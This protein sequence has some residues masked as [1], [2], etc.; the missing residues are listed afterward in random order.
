MAKQRYIDTHFWDDSF[1][2]SLRPY[3]RY[4]FMY[5]LTNPHTNICGIYELSLKKIAAESALTED[6]VKEIMKQFEDARKIFYIDGWVYIKNFIRHQSKNPNVTKG[7]ENK[8]AEIPKEIL[9]KIAYL[10]AMDSDPL[11]TEQPKPELEPKPRLKPEPKYTPSGDKVR[12]ATPIQE[13]VNHLFTLKGWANKDKDFYAKN[14]VVYA[15]YLRPAKDLLFLCEDDIEE[16]KRCLDKMHEW[17]TSRD[18]DWSIETVFKKWPELD[19]LKAKEKKPHWDGCRVFQRANG[20]RWWI[21]RGGEI[22]ELGRDLKPSE[23]VWK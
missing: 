1:I 8:L 15:R 10:K 14:K 2:E 21:I 22:K 17:A 19:S 20:G 23:I 16:A 9:D 4:L 3:E 5:F 12:K 18:L 11:G 13:I 6:R 7:I